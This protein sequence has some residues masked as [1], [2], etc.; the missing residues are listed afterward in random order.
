MGIRS[1]KEEKR[2]DGEVEESRRVAVGDG[3]QRKRKE[4]V[5]GSRQGERVL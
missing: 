3:A 5:G 4:R 1:G 2:V